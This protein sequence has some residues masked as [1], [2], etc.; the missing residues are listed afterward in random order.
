MTENISGIS[1]AEHGMVPLNT[2]D[3]IIGKII[4]S[5][6]EPDIEKK[7]DM[8]IAVLVNIRLLDKE[9][10]ITDNRDIKENIETIYQRLFAET[11]RTLNTMQSPTNE[12][13]YYCREVLKKLPIR[14]GG[15]DLI[16]DI[17]SAAEYFEEG[18][19]GSDPMMSFAGD[20][21]KE[22]HRKL[23]PRILSKYLK[24]YL[25][26]VKNSNPE[27]IHRPVTG[28]VRADAKKEDPK[29]I[30][31][32]EEMN[33]KLSY[34]WDYEKGDITVVKG[35]LEKNLSLFERCFLKK[36]MQ[37]FIE[38]CT[39]SYIQNTHNLVDCLK[40]LA[41]FKMLIKKSYFEK[42]IELYDF[43]N[44]DLD[45]GRLVFIFTNDLTNNHYET[46]TTKTFVNASVWCVN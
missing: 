35:N 1:A 31:L 25:E 6:Q 24:P 14:S 17:R 26:L 2:W 22:V 15:G 5:R 23:S 19:N 39:A 32:A 13:I 29:F 45:I 27:P 28:S 33:D 38:I 20:L 43:I 42:R 36:E 3:K 12:Y 37:T 40:R 7:I 21:R 46:A 18:R 44:L 9:E 16:G 4:E 10:K 30:E 34:L 11:L 41:S 8:L